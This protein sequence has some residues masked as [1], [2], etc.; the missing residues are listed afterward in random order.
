[1][2][3]IEKRDGHARPHRPHSE[4]CYTHLDLLCCVPISGRWRDRRTDVVIVMKRVAWIPLCLDSPEPSHLLRS[5]R[6][7]DARLAL[8]A[9][10]VEIDPARRPF[11]HRL[12]Q[13]PGVVQVGLVV[14]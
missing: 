14:L 12:R 9:D 2:T 8:I 3:R 4:N 11:L 5:E 1:M 10:V 6:R 13:A 7:L